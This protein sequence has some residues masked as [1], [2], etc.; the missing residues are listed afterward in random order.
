MKEDGTLQYNFSW[1]GRFPSCLTI[2]TPTFLPVKL[3]TDMVLVLSF[4]VAESQYGYQDASHHLYA[5]TRKK[6]EKGKMLFPQEASFVICKESRFFS[7]SIVFK[8]DG[9][10]CLDHV[11]WDGCGQI[12]FLDPVMALLAEGTNAGLRRANE[13]TSICGHPFY[14]H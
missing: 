13:L 5:Q 1:V 10:K 4:V 8:I 11:W 3:L 6:T 14:H 2:Q 12:L 7:Y 9:W